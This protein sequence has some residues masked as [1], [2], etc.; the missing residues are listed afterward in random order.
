MSRSETLEVFKKNI[1]TLQKV[2]GRP[3]TGGRPSP[4]GSAILDLCD[5]CPD[6]PEGRFELIPLMYICEHH[7]ADYASRA[8]DVSWHLALR[9]IEVQ[10]TTVFSMYDL[11]ALSKSLEGGD[12]NANVLESALSDNTKYKLAEFSVVSAVGTAPTESGTQPGAVTAPVSSSTTASSELS[13][14]LIKYLESKGSVEAAVKEL[15]RLQELSP[16]TVRAE[17][18]A[19]AAMNAYELIK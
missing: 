7:G 1:N 15:I 17:S 10:P 12:F 13:P 6:I 9:G 2:L 18:C 19:K 16:T 5:K 3:L 14:E 11:D 8:V 4:I